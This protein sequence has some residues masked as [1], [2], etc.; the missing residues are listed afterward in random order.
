MLL[1]AQ[2]QPGADPMAKLKPSATPTA[3]Q[4]IDPMAALRLQPTTTDPDPMAR[5]LV[6]GQRTSGAVIAGPLID[7]ISV[8]PPGEGREL[9]ATM[10]NMCH[11]VNLVRQQRLAPERWDYLW[12]W[13]IT[14]QGMPR[15]PD[16]QKKQILDYL[17]ANFSLK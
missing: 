17:K 13:M 9:T 6:R 8:L 14:N 7:P 11:S 5:L 16:P 10:C 4:A 12:E 2:A 3:V 15:L 1:I